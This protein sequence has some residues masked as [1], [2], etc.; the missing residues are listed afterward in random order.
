[1]NSASG[2]TFAEIVKKKI[3]NQK[4]AKKPVIEAPRVINEKDVPVNCAP[5]TTRALP[6]TRAAL[7]DG[8]D[9]HCQTTASDVYW[10][11]H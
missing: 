7:L 8:T 10:V 5:K 2:G 3:P 9:M 6:P 4:V 1:M 11:C